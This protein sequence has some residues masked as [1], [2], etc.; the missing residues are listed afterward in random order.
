MHHEHGA[1]AVAAQH[2]GRRWSVEPNQLPERQR[3]RPVRDQRS[4]Q[5]HGG[6][7]DRIR[8][9]HAYGDHALRSQD[10]RDRAAGDRDLEIRGNGGGIEAESRELRRLDRRAQDRRGAFSPIEEVDELGTLCELL[11]DLLGPS[12]EAARIVAEDADL[13]RLGVPG[14]IGEYVLEDLDVLEP[15]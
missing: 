15:D 10:L 2:R 12:M 1:Q 8:V 14:Q 9:A 13:D 7:T 5:G 11:A 4:A 3:H 6:P